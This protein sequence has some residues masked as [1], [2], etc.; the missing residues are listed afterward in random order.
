[1]NGLKTS[2]GNII[3]YSTCMY[4]YVIY[5]YVHAY[6]LHTYLPSRRS[7]LL[8]YTCEQMSARKDERVFVFSMA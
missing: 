1:M 7:T 6:Y 5:M 3:M 8:K 4:S 2:K